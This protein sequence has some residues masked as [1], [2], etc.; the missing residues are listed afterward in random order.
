MGNGWIVW[1]GGVRAEEF[2]EGPA[3]R[4]SAGVPNGEAVGINADLHRGGDAVIAVDECVQNG[5]ETT[6][7]QGILG[8]RTRRPVSLAKESWRSSK[9]RKRSA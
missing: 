7:V 8:V 3:F 5:F 9:E 1:C 6:A 4:K 2:F